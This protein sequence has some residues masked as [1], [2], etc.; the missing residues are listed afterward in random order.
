MA[1]ETAV[2]SSGAQVPFAD[3]ASR[4]SAR[5]IDLALLALFNFMLWGALYLG[6]VHGN[7]QQPSFALLR[8]LSPVRLLLYLGYFAVLTARSGQTLGKRFMG[9]Q[10]RDASGGL[11]GAGMSTWRAMADFLFYTFSVV[12]IGLVDYLWMLRQKESRTLHDLLAR[13]T[14][15]R[16]KPFPGRASV[17]WLEA[18]SVLIILLASGP[19]NMVHVTGVKRLSNMSPTINQGEHWEANRIAYRHHTPAVGDV[20]C[21]NGTDIEAET[22]PVA[23]VVGVAGECLA[24][25]DGKVQRVAQSP[26]RPAADA[27]VVIVPTECLAV[28]GDNRATPASAAFPSEPNRGPAEFPPGWR[29]PPPPLWPGVP[30]ASSP[31][32]IVRNKDVAGQV[33]GIT[34]PLSHIRTVR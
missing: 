17:P 32:L 7:L 25:R 12:L 20:V 23:R 24:F 8:V 31:I 30:T 4:F 1:E 26:P 19:Q 16:I 15:R 6:V 29:R 9:I 27:D 2:E 18:I 5:L 11:P 13:T 14:V 28:L 22:E 21:F 33:V 10:V 3:F 34:W